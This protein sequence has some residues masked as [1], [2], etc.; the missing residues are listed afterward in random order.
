MGI[1]I[2]VMGLVIIVLLISL[3]MFERKSKELSDKYYAELEKLSNGEP[4]TFFEACE[5]MNN[6]SMKL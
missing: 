6:H 4:N 1:M 5:E 2:V 3:M